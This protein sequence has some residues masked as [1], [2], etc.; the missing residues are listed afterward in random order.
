MT[1]FELASAL[2]VHLSRHPFALTLGIGILLRLCHGRGA[3]PHASA[4][5]LL[6]AYTVAGIAGLLAYVGVIVFYATGPQYFDAAEPTMAA[7][8][9]LFHVG[10][11]VYHELEAGERYSHIYGP[12]PFIVQGV[13]LNIFGATIA[14]SKWVGGVLAMAAMALT[15]LVLRRKTSGHRAVV[16]V[17]ICAVILL[18]FR[19]SSFWT[20]PEP[21]QV[22]CVAAALA[23]AHLRSRNLATVLAGMLIG[24]LWNLKI[25]GPLYSFP[26]FVL[27]LYRTGWRRAVAAAAIVAVAAF[28]PF[29]LFSNVSFTTYLAWVRL[30]AQT[31]L[32]LAILRQNIEWTAY[33]IVPLVLAWHATARDADA[34]ADGEWSAVILTLGVATLGVIVA[35]SK[36]GAGPYHLLPFVPI[37]AYLVAARI[38]SIAVLIG[39]PDVAPVAAA[40]LIV[41]VITAVAQ[42]IQFVQVMA[43]RRAIDVADEIVRLAAAYSG[44]VEMGYALDDPITFQRPVLVFRNNRYVL[45]QPAVG[46]H[47]LAGLEIPP[48]TIAALRECR[49]NYWLL[50]KGEPPFGGVNMY[51]AVRFR[52]LFPASFRQAFFGS[53]RLVEST[54][55]FD[56]WQCRTAARASGS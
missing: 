22:F 35:G 44:V 16:L 3:R 9:W 19:N 5:R 2:A 41:G 47:L 10:Q 45:D 48:A 33:L 20:R 24:V 11:P 46:E 23:A 31:G 28:L 50:P 8:G 52:P 13:A 27:L 54:A 42:Q 25:T 1:L 55:H 56:V 12:M 49:V 26:L 34:R 39:R 18:G 29:V 4:G 40:F 51:P 32:D 7:I 21:L 17:G 36:P 6:Q 43:S 37:V 15:F 53:H 30:S 38:G 14:T